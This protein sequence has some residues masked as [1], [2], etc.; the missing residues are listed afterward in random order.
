MVP[1]ILQRASSLL[2]WAETQRD[3]F[4][5]VSVNRWLPGTERISVQRYTR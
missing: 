4:G 1:L 3:E 2:P 5:A